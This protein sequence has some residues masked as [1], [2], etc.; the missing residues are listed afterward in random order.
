MQIDFHEWSKNNKSIINELAHDNT[1]GIYISYLDFSITSRCSLKCRDCLALMQY[2]ENPTNYDLKKMIYAL[3]FLRNNVECIGELR[4]IGGEPFVNSEVYEI[5]SKALENDKIKNVV[6][7][8]N[9]TVLPS[10]KKMTG[11]DN[12]KIK[13]YLSD[14]H[15]KCQKINEFIDLIDPLGFDYYVANFKNW[16]AH[17]AIQYVDLSEEERNRLYEK[18]PGKTCPVVIEDRFYMCEYVANACILN[19]VPS[20]DDNYY[21]MRKKST[22]NNEFKKYLK[23][24]KAPNACRY[25]SRLITCSNP[26]LVEPA[27]QLSKP[28]KYNH[29]N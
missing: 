15:I 8:T 7:F 12:K 25:C 6:I 29:Y 28:L 5:C 21:D 23:R 24:D 26:K 9:A 18:C 27:I 19:A 1:E 13:F 16:I 4:I 20:S 10:A 14:Y 2:Y 17:S 3:E 11:W 22:G